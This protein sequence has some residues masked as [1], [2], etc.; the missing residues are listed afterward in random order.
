MA[1]ERQFGQAIDLKA[2]LPQVGVINQLDFNDALQRRLSPID[3]QGMSASAGSARQAERRQE[4]RIQSLRDAADKAQAAA[5]QALMTAQQSSAILPGRGSNAG[6]LFMSPIAGLKPTFGFGA[7]YK[8][9]VAGNANHQGLDFATK[10]GTQILAPFGGKIIE[11]GW[12]NTG[13]GNSVRIQ[14]DNGLFGILGHML[15][16]PNVSVGDIV[17]AGQ[18]LGLVG[19]TGNS[20]G[21]HLHFEVR[22]NPYDPKSSI[23][24]SYLFG[25]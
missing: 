16:K 10:A 25:W 23:D 24:P 1:K 18:L 20:S 3:Q 15:N 12:N 14:F 22:K 6:G 17:T 7:Q 4:A 21:N 9:P 5:Q 13:F 2:A 19:S 8:N 11:S